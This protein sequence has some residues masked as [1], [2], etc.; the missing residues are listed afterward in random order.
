MRVGQAVV[1]R[2]GVVTAV[3][4]VEG[5][6]EAI[7]RGAA[8]AGTGGV[9][10]KVAAPDHD[11]RFDVPAVGL[12]TLEAARAGGVAVLAVESDRVAVLDREAVV[13]A[14]DAAGIAV[15]AVGAP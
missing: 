5:T 4:A 14:A 7:R 1:V 15:I 6:T 9:V 13:E 11:Y 10:V 12:E 8:Q 2:H 3:E